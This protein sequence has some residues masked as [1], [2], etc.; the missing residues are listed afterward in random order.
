HDSQHGAIFSLTQQQAQLSHYYYNNTSH[1]FIIEALTIHLLLQKATSFATLLANVQSLYPLFKAE[2]FLALDEQKLE[3]RI[4]AVLQLLLQK[5][6]IFCENDRWIA[7]DDPQQ[8]LQGLSLPI[9]EFLQRYTTV[10]ARLTH[11]NAEIAS[12]L[13]A[14]KLSNMLQKE[15]AALQNSRDFAT[16]LYDPES[17]ALTLHALQQQ[18]AISETGVCHTEHI[19]Q[20]QNQLL[21]LSQQFTQPSIPQQAASISQVSI[22]QEEK[23]S[24]EEESLLSVPASQQA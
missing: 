13:T 5:E 10:L 17:M 20:L 22:S 6:L 18:G 23:S 9:R 24:L 4:T 21:A 7:I 1:L 16:D 2:F 12:P 8:Q 14:Q 11:S 3:A 19:V 15:S